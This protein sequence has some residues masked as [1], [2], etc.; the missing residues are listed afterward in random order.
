MLA[1]IESSSFSPLFLKGKKTKK[2]RNYKNNFY[3]HNLSMDG[4]GNAYF[5]GKHIYKQG[6]SGEKERLVSHVNPTSIGALQ[7][8]E[9]SSKVFYCTWHSTRS[10][11]AMIN[12]ETSQIQHYPMD[13][14]AAS[15]LLCQDESKVLVGDFLNQVHWK[16]I[17]TD[18]SGGVVFGNRA[19]NQA[20]NGL[21]FDQSYRIAVGK[22]NHCVEIFDIRQ[23]DRPITTYTNH[24]AAVRAVDFNINHNLMASGCGSNNPHLQIWDANNGHTLAQM[25]AEAQI[26]EIKWLPNIDTRQ[27]SIYLLLAHGFNTECALALWEYCFDSHQL[28]KVSNLHNKGNDEKCLDLCIDSHNQKVV[29]ANTNTNIQSFELKSDEDNFLTIS[30]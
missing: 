7:D 26:T 14:L 1:E 4:Y 6:L 16:D 8:T 25:P 22:Q 15:V 2:C 12:L 10:Q 17:R 27:R 20:I 3:F 13:N 29:L 30:I 5:A 24:Q 21:S 9:A 19:Q 28:F 18:G 23:H 11:L